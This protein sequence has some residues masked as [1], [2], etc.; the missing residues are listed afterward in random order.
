MAAPGITTIKRFNYRG[1]PNEEFSNTYHSA[2]AIPDDDTFRNWVADIV[3]EEAK[4]LLTE[5]SIIRAYGYADTDK[6]S[7]FVW[8]FTVTP[9]DIVPGLFPATG[10]TI[11]PG[12][13][14]YWCRWDTGRKN[15]KGKAIYL[16]KYFHPGLIEP[17]SNDLLHPT[18]K[19]ALQT[20]A[21][22]LGGTGPNGFTLAGPDG[23]QP[24]GPNEASTY[25]TTR[26]LKRRGKRP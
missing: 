12:D 22:T 21:D 14:A 18:L 3:N 2:A 16:R 8:D 13:T 23:Q 7:N 10:A 19:A 24:P 9:S 4:V 15:S 1:D 11:T 25:I 6:P 20:F 17:G 5:V 26:T